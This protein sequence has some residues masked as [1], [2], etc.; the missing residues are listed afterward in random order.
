MKEQKLIIFASFLL[1]F[2]LILS[3]IIGAL[4]RL[5]NLQAFFIAILLLLPILMQ[6]S[7]A[8]WKKL[9]KL[10]RLQKSTSLF[11]NELPLNRKQAAQRSLKSIDQ[12]IDRIHNN[13][14]SEGLKLERR[15]IEE[16]FNRRDLE[17]VIFGTGSSGKTSLIRALLNEI[18]GNVSSAM[19]ST[20]KINSY[21]LR[22]RGL[23]RAIKLI[24]T[25][26]ILEGGKT[27]RIRE[28]HALLKASRSDLILFVVDGD[29]REAEFE[30]IQGLADVGKRLFLI[31][32][33]VDLRTTQEEEQLI[34]ILKGK[35]KGLI[36]PSDVISTTSSPQSIPVP[37]H[38]PL[39]PQPEIE[40][41]VRRLAKVLYQD[42]EELL[43]DNILLQ[44]RNLNKS[45]KQLLDRQRAISANKC[46][47]KYSWISS[48]VVIITP[49]PGI[50][51]LG[52]AAVNTQMV[53]EIAKVYGIELTKKRA[54]ELAISV[55]R[56]LTGLGIV[57]GGVSMIGS[58]LSLSLPTIL[59]G[60]VIQSITAAWLTKVAGESFISYFK[61][62]QDWGD[63]GIQE[64]VQRQYDINRREKILGE[65]L[66][67][68]MNRV[69][70]PLKKNR[71]IQLPP[72][73]KLQEEEESSD[74][75]HPLM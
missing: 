6:I 12:L 47:E 38:K 55:A 26:G 5:I 75:E 57:Q 11:I 71:R 20:S 73:Q 15:R 8:K 31:L 36:E 48:G 63:G 24:D 22:L 27:G 52:T 25:P 39:Q 44:C 19:G 69:V 67:A 50:E 43:A 10:K 64:E 29:L 54:K 4:L 13:V 7:P 34:S 61:Q 60:R 70:E 18:V 58:A 30:I 23:D 62:D 56:T 33:K 65:F 16:E 72:H 32:N 14:A 66:E 49:L 17:I 40:D 21:R 9:L 37:G 74:H 53:I 46:V 41:L 51:L 68:A 3:G 35:T 2:I 45:G 28:R 59:V 42:G 1:A